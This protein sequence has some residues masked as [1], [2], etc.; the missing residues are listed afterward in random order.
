MFLAPDNFYTSLFFEPVYSGGTA[1]V[2]F[3]LI[4][5]WDLIPGDIF[6]P[7]SLVL[8]KTRLWLLGLNEEMAKNTEW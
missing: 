2:N 7:G 6:E 8:Q 5:L 3:L 4:S 1:K